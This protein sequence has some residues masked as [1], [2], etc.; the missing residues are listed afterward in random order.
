MSRDLIIA[1]IGAA[2]LILSNLVTPIVNYIHKKKLNNKS[3]KL[4]LV[5]ENVKIDLHISNKLEDIKDSIN[6]DTIW[7]CQ[8]HNGGYYYPTGKSMQKFS[9]TY[10]LTSS[11]V[12]QNLFQ[13]IPT[14]LFSK[15]I[16]ELSEDN[17][18]NIPN[19]QNYN[20]YNLE[21]FGINLKYNS[22]YLFPLFTIDNKFVGFIGIG[23]DNENNLDE[24]TINKIKIEA[25]SI[26]GVLM[27]N[28]DKK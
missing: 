2:G 9:M 28:Y 8:F 18:I 19:F 1:L 13:N 12:M 14:G 24:N 25:R 17:V 4:D 20:S 21:A 7:L 11:T 10:E 16:N 3:K 23:Y 5:K 6:A 27:N 22:I 26:A 15:A